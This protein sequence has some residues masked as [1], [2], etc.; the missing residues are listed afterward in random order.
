MSSCIAQLF[1]IFI[2]I[3]TFPNNVKVIEMLLP[4]SNFQVIGF[5]DAGTAWAG[6]NP[7][8]EDNPLNTEIFS[9]GQPGNEYVFVTVNYF[10]DPIVAGYGIGARALLFGYFV[11][12]D[13]GWGI[14]TRVIQKPRLHV[15][16]GF[17][18]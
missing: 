8:R 17:D 4:S 16:L 1:S 6:R 9:E 13:Y 3:Q 10:R 18:F 5:F 7:F 15:A 2:I 12:L 14:E 11:R